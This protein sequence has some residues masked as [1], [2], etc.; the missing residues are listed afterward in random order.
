MRN[1]IFAAAAVVLFGAVSLTACSGDDAD[2]SGAQTSGTNSDDA[3]YTVAYVPT[4]MNNPF[5]MAVLEG[6]QA[7]LEPA[8][9][10]IVTVD[11][12]NDQ[13][14]MND[15]IGDLIAQ[16]VDLITIAPVDATAVRPALR[17]AADAGIP[18]VNIDA[19][20]TDVDLVETIVASNNEQAGALVAKDM[21]ERLPE[22]S[23]VAVLHCPAGGACISRLAGFEAESDGY[24][25]I[26]QNLDGKG[27]TNVALPLATD[28]L[29][30]NPAL[31]AI[32]GINDPMALGAVQA[33]KEAGREGEVLIYGV[34]GSP[35]GKSAIERG[36]LTGTGA[37]SPITMGKESALASI[38]I[39]AGKTVEHEIV[40]DTH[41][42]ISDNISEHD[43][44]KWQ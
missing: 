17:Q 27:D 31:A 35:D 44:N 19:P 7:E 20:V 2:T 33:V 34:D 41:L 30:A 14:K 22:G 6:M 4:T 39:L 3:A 26:V 10:K 8:G 38:A 42:I 32:F 1:R 15:Q 37:Q 21:M 40:I 5:W 18:V 23:E 11:P 25:S 29:T 12:A 24:F 16:G 36:V 9:I 13:T 28:M 43:I